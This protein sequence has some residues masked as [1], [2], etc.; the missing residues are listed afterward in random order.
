MR[1]NV[2]VLASVFIT[3][4]VFCSLTAH[5]AGDLTKQNP[6]SLKV[7]LGNT[8][9]ELRFIP[10]TLRLESGKLYKLVLTNPSPQKHY[11]SSVGMSQAVYT[12]KVQINGADGNAIAEVNGGISEI[13]VYPG[14]TAEW[15]FVPVKTGNFADLKCTIAGHAEGGM[16]GQIIIE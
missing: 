4:C 10:G 7:N 1:A 11:F 16:V 2:I 6:I 3:V 13:E 5:A 12:R 8:K 14:G 15:W 9:N